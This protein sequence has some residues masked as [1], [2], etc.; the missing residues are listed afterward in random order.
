M[1]PDAVRLINE[2]FEAVRQFLKPRLNAIRCFLTEL[3]LR[4]FDMNPSN[5]QMIQDDFI[6]MR[7][8]FNA[9]ADDLH[10]LLI[11]SRLLGIM[12]GKCTLDEDSWNTAKAMETERR[13]RIEALPKLKMK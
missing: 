6:A 9:T 1:D 8:K 4:D 7:S 13:L 2:T 3:R 11:V 10:I 12:Q 5:M